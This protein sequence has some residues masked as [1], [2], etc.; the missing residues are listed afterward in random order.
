MVIYENSECMSPLKCIGHKCKIIP[1]IKYLNY[2]CP[3]SKCPICPQKPP[4]KNVVTYFD[5]NEFPNY[6][7]DKRSHER[8]KIHLGLPY[9]GCK[10]L[11][12]RD[13]TCKAIC[14]NGINRVCHIRNTYYFPGKPNNTWNCAIKT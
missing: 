6:Y 12:A 7:L 8:T 11:C 10:E 1:V 5:F 3:D 13:S 14:F 9:G 4:C 2:T